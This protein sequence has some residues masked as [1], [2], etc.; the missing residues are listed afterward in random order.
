MSCR[1]YKD[2][3][4]SS[5]VNSAADALSTI[6]SAVKQDLKA[7]DDYMLHALDTNIPLIQAIGNHILQHGGKK[8]RP[9]SLALSARAL[10]YEGNQH[11]ILAVMIEFIHVATLLHDDVVDQS[12]MRRG[13]ASANSIWGNPASVLVG[14]FFYS[15]SFEML[16]EVNRIPVFEVMAQATRRISEGE[17]MQLVQLQAAKTTEEEYLSTIDRKTATLFRAGAQIGSIIS[18]QPQEIQQQMADYGR[19]LGIAFQLIDDYLDYAGD[20][21]TIGKKVGDDL[22]EGKL[23]LP[24]IYARE[25]VGAERLQEINAALEHPGDCSIE[26]ICHIVAASGAL[27]YT[28]KL[29]Q[30]YG[31]RA[32]RCLD[33]LDQSV[34]RDLLIKL[35]EFSYSRN[36]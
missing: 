5:Q 35:A 14:D 27:E 31:D 23:T 13:R 11:I 18:D 28:S 36:Y 25:H 3:Q 34:Y 9:I 21:E 19:N 30:S 4:S 29:A 7:I 10:G 1:D 12:I 26:N 22:S 16:T 33:F 15:R 17:I 2:G 8:L 32:V 6:R 20:T 24:L